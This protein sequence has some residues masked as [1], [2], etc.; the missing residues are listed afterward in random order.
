MRI[1]MLGLALLVAA[2]GTYNAN[3]AALVPRATPRMTTG[4][5]LEGLAQLNVGA[6]SVT[7]LGAPG[8]GDPNAGVEIP[9]TQLHG[10]LRARIGDSVS[11]GFMYENGLDKGAE[12]LKTTQ[13]PVDG[14]NVQGY[15]LT[16][17]MSI[18]TGDPRF[19][20]GIGIDAMIW[21]V[22]YVEYLTCAAGE[23]CFPFLIMDTGKDLVETF[24]GSITPSFKPSEDVSV[25]GGLTVRQHPTIDQKV[26]DLNAFDSPEVES[27]PTNFIISGGAEVSFA[28]GALLASA[29]AYWDISRDPAKY[30]PGFGLMLSVPFG[31]KRADAP[32]PPPILVPV[33][34]YPQP[35]YPPPG[36]GYPPPEYAPPTYPAPAPAPEPVPE[37]PPPA[38]APPV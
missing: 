6:S 28:D 8:V 7:S 4:Q 34:V 15:G 9:S 14:G 21:S 36:P 27:G 37:A 35:G 32:P 16:M 25:F 30:R 38:P 26:V 17:D 23:T 11:I 33:P 24:A 10:D 1:L 31:K 20:I 5:P 19:R 2:C 13:P 3:R 18:P 12:Q 22:P 29:V